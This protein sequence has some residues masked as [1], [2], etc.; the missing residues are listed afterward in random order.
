MY[1]QQAPPPRMPACPVC[2]G[3]PLATDGCPE[4]AR[5]RRVARRNGILLAIL[6]SPIFALFLSPALYPGEVAIALPAIAVWL[7]GPFVWPLAA[8]KARPRSRAFA[9]G[10]GIGHALW[11]GLIVLVVG[12]GLAIVAVGMPRGD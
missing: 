10:I 6:L 5:G 8:R 11:I 7:F 3:E 12:G 2:G 9:M 1:R 4:C